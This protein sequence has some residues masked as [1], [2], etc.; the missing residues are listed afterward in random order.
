MHFVLVR[1]ELH[2]FHF[3]H[4]QFYSE[5]YTPRKTR[6]IIEIKRVET[7]TSLMLILEWEDL[8]FL[9][10][11]SKFEFVLEAKIVLSPSWEISYSSIDFDL[12]PKWLS[13]SHL[14]HF[15]IHGDENSSLSSYTAQDLTFHTN[16]DSSYVEQMLH[17][18]WHRSLFDKNWDFL[19]RA[20]NLR[21][22]FAFTINLF[23]NADKYVK[24][25]RFTSVSTHTTPLSNCEDL[26]MT[27]FEFRFQRIRMFLLIE[28]HFQY[29]LTIISNYLQ[30]SFLC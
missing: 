21:K 14:L 20:Y 27:F 10:L 13:S 22:S 7:L 2:I 26:G 1:P 25:T 15:R 28:F 12:H 17:W 8:F 3:E 16:L 4:F 19:D 5:D 23:G 18:N 6:I 9:D 29:S 11:F 30:I 24:P